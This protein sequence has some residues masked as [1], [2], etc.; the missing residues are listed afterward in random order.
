MTIATATKTAANTEAKAAKVHPAV[1][2]WLLCEAVFE[3]ATDNSIPSLLTEDE[4]LDVQAFTA[5][6][7]KR[8]GDLA[9]VEAY[10]AVLTGI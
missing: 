10:L 5:L 8:G 9:T 3:M 6:I 7:V 1:R 4:D 2:T